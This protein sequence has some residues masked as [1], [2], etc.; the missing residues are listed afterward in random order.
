MEIDKVLLQTMLRKFWMST[1]NEICEGATVVFL[2]RIGL[3]NREIKKWIEI[4]VK[5]INLSTANEILNEAV[6]ETK[7]YYLDDEE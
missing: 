5:N 1:H 2:Q 4:N 6:K 7:N 3:T